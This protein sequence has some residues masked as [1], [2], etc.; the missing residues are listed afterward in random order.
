MCHMFEVVFGLLDDLYFGR[1][2]LFGVVIRYVIHTDCH[3]FLIFSAYVILSIDADTLGNLRK[4]A[5]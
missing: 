1:C 5:S 4:T 3:K 2:V